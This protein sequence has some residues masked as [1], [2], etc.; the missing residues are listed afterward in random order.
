MRVYAVPHL[1]RL[2]LVLHA[3]R[4]L[5]DFL[6]LLIVLKAEHQIVQRYREQGWV[7]FAPMIQKRSVLPRISAF[8]EL[9]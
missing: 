5:Y 7:F 2:R 3:E 9:L 1:E 6:A 4:C 8:R